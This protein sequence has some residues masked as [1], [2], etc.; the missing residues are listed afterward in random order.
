M[1]TRRL[2]LCD[3]TAADAQSHFEGAA[4][5][6][7]LE[8]QLAIWS[9]SY[10]EMINGMVENAAEHRES[11]AS[12]RQPGHRDP[13]ETVTEAADGPVLLVVGGFAQCCY[14]TYHWQISHPRNSMNYL[15]IRFT[16]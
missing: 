8:E 12:D 6:A 7:Y 5:E 2:R 1:K 4:D 3:H 11:V 15:L 13:C 10:A 14:R 16:T 9:Q